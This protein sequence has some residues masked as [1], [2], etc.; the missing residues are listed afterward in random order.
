MSDGML[1]PVVDLNILKETV[2]VRIPKG[3]RWKEP[4]TPNVEIIRY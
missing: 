2:R 3:A 1:D 4:L